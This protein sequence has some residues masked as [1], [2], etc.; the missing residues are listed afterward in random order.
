MLSLLLLSRYP[1]A[2]LKQ[3]VQDY[4]KERN[5]KKGKSSA[6]LLAGLEDGGITED[7]DDTQKQR[8]DQHV[9]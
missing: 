4:I 6:N 2:G 8:L 3:A 9:R 1:L 5:Q 7:L